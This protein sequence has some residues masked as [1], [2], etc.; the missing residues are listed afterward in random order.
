MN[1]QINSM[2]MSS[3]NLTAISGISSFSRISITSY[4]SNKINHQKVSIFFGDKNSQEI[5]SHE[6]H[7]TIEIY[8]IIISKGFTFNISQKT[9][10][11]KVLDLAIN[12]SNGCQSLKK[13]KNILNLI[14]DQ[15]I[16]RK[17]VMIKKEAD[18][19]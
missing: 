17:L 15:N 13:I 10:F 9:R 5:S 7:L 4:V 12:V 1:I 16:Q 11:K 19:F 2:I 14:H 18:I 8:G 3:S 6:S